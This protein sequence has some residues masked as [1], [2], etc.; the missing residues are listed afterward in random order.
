M[1]DKT[2]DDVS[3]GFVNDT[4]L[5]VSGD[6]SFICAPLRRNPHPSTN[7]YFMIQEVVLLRSRYTIQEAVSG[8]GNEFL[9]FV[10]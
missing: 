6:Q 5:S 3:D 10:P 4:R 8:H 2:F 7:V 9:A 1:H